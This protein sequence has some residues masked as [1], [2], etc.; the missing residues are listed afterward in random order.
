VQGPEP[1][2]GCDRFLK[3]RRHRVETDLWKAIKVINFLRSV[4]APARARRSE[5]AVETA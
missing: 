1:D 3:T 5:A 4:L 2:L